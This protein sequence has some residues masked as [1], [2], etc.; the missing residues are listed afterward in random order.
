M[1][2]QYDVGV[3][4]AGILG[5]AHAYHLA[6][7]GLR[8]VVFERHPRAQGASIRNFG[9]IW[10]IGQPLGPLYDL[11]RRSRELWLEVL[12][13]SGL[14]YRPGGSL[15][16]AYHDDE[17]QVLSEFVAEAS[18]QDRPCELWAPAQIAS[19]FPTIIQTG[20]RAA[21]W[22]PI[23]LAVDPRQVIAELP[24]WLNRA[25]GVHFAFGTTVM[26]YEPPGIVTTNGNW[27]ARRLVIC[28]GADFRELAPA[29]FADSGLVPC[30]LQMMRSQP[31]GDRFQVGT[32]LAAGLTLRH[33]ASFAGCP[34]LPA[35]ARRL[36]SELPDYGRLGIHVLVSQ[37]ERGELTLGDSHEYGDAIEPF[38]NPH[39]DELI[40]NYLKTF[41]TIPDL[42]IAARWHGIYVKHPTAPYVIARPT[43]E[44]LAVTGVG[45]AGMTLSFGLAEQLLREEG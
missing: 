40:L 1:T 4:G 35:L 14:W 24:A 43:P 33:Y 41:L 34:T 31:V 30:K 18:P 9:M 45:G 13:A 21:L 12:Q 37:N 19:R 16:L 10:P 25:L 28:T 29:A 20:L 6:R 26:R 3:V 8:V 42:V 23:E 2:P 15:H 38:D 5:L 17:A 22:S 36:D 7:R 27:S 44:T 11:A 32:H 39:I